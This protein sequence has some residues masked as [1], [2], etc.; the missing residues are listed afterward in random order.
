MCICKKLRKYNIY[1]KIQNGKFGVKITES[2]SKPMEKINRNKN[3]TFSVFWIKYFRCFEDFYQQRM[4]TYKNIRIL[5][6]YIMNSEIF[7]QAYALERLY[8]FAIQEWRLLIFTGFS[9][10]EWT[11]IGGVTTEETY[12]L[13]NYAK[14]PILLVNTILGRLK[15]IPIYTPKAKGWY[16]LWLFECKVSANLKCIIDFAEIEIY[17]L[18]VRF[19]YVH[20]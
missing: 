6:S 12:F 10:Y 16:S 13:A 2:L 19:P 8:C 17:T 20:K 1:Q 9:R 18:Y 4:K 11:F 5:I 15:N 7:S 14:I 3:Q